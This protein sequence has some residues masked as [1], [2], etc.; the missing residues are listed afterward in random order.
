MAE[1][2]NGHPSFWLE[3]DPTFTPQ[4]GTLAAMM[5]HARTTTLRAVRDLTVEQLDATP[6]GFRNSIG[7]LLA[8]ICAVERIHQIISFECRD[9]FQPDVFEPYRAAMTFGAQGEPVRGRSLDWYLRELSET[10]AV[11]L[12]TLARRDDAWLMSGVQAPG[13]D[14]VNHH[15]S[16]FHVMEDEVNHRGQMRLLRRLVL[17]PTREG[18]LAL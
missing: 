8:H 9:P 17:S 11:T 6:A 18:E 5:A 3:A 14:D 12:A 13:F 15:Y 10:R 2:Q 4:I 1:F 16:W 7:M